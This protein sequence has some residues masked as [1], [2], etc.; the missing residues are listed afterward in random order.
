MANPCSSDPSAGCD[1]SQLIAAIN[2]CCAT[3][4]ANLTAI[5]ANLALIIAAN[6]ACCT[7]LNAKL[8]TVI[9][10]LQTVISN[11]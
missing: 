3:T 4:N 9:S 5:N 10:L 11:Q 1:N 6:A 7:Q 8:D 2:A